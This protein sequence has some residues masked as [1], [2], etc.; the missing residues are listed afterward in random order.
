MGAVITI[1]GIILI[2]IYFVSLDSKKES[3]KEKLSDAVDTLSH[4]AADAVSEMAYKLTETKE[5]KDIRIA[6][7]ILADKN[8]RFF[9]LTQYHKKDEINKLFEINETFKK[10]LDTLGL[11]EERWVNLG[12]HLLYISVIKHYSEFEHNDVSVRRS[13]IEKWSKDEYVKDDIAFL[14]EALS[15]YH[16]D[17][18]E[19]IKFGATVLD[20]YKIYSIPDIKEYGIVPVYR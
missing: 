2:I 3:P 16:I 13:V 4:S 8:G 20:M 6:R 7:E 15:F 11:T 10:A 18:E 5:K 14:L 17:K 19:W 1:I 12:R 9:N